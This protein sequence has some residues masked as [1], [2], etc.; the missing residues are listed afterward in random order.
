[1]MECSGLG[2][3]AGLR[4]IADTIAR[5]VDECCGTRRSS[6][7]WCCCRNAQEWSQEATH[8]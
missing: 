2:K 7:T 8:G 1:M 4:L 6:F 3:M 5:I